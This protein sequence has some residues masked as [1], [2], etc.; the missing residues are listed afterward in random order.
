MGVILWYQVNFLGLGTKISSDVYS[1]DYLDDAEINIDYALGQPGRFDIHF[2]NLPLDVNKNVANSLETS[3]SGPDGGVKVEISLGYLD[4][5]SSQKKVLTGRVDTLQASMHYP[6]LGARLSGYE[7]ASYKLLNTRA[8]NGKGNQA[9]VHLSLPKNHNDPDVTVTEAVNFILKAAGNPTVNDVQVVDGGT[10]K[11]GSAASKTKFS[12]DAENAF[13]LLDNIAHR[14]QAEILVQEGA[15]QFGPAIK[16][17]PPKT[18]ELPPNLAAIAALITGDDTLITV[19]SLEGARLAEFQPVQLGQTSKQGVFTDLPKEATQ[20]FDFT[21]LGLPSLRAGQAV[22]TSVDGYQN[23]FKPFR[24]L[25]VTH[26][27][28]PDTGYVCR[29]RAVKFQD[30]QSNRSFSDKARGASAMAIADRIAGKVKDVQVTFPSVDVGRVKA[31]KT[32][33]RVASLYY[34]QEKGSAVSTP[35]VDL[36]VP[37]GES[38]L[39][40][41]PL[42]APF[43]WHNVGLTV[44]VYEGMR[45]LLNQVRD[46]RDDS[47]VTGFLWANNPQMARPQSQDGDWWLCLPTEVSGT[48]KL[49]TGKGVNDLVAADGRR[50]IEAVGLKVSVGKKACSEVGK[51]PTEGDADVLLIS[52]SSGTTIQVDKDGNVTVDGKGK[53]V[54]LACGGAT[55]TVGDGK[56][57]IS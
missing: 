43:A 34:G 8:L 51:R 53:S 14:Y 47:V 41:K 26:A 54:S 25:Q 27:F 6:P 45:A 33:D 15:L 10:V 55:L 13:N 20:A 22:V 1:G 44:P 50:V 28:S 16:Y 57:S 46:S 32:S 35:S 24:I 3:K 18:P 21:A 38:V 29:G 12:E 40:S 31:V 48:P 9:T 23:P 11:A 42:A 36:D 52:H 5:P 19:D 17:P 56:V 39:V 49:P 37:D 2:K 7:E 30:K 4:D